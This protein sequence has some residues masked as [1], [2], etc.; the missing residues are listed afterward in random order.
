MSAV[1]HSSQ[2]SHAHRVLQST[3]HAPHHTAGCSLL[4]VTPSRARALRLACVRAARRAQEESGADAKRRRTK[5]QARAAPH[6]NSQLDAPTTTPRR[7]CSPRRSVPEG[8]LGALPRCRPGGS[9]IEEG[10]RRPPQGARRS[11]AHKKY[12]VKLLS[13]SAVVLTRTTRPTAVQHRLER[14][15]RLHRSPRAHRAR[16][17]RREGR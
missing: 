8:F 16:V 9:P 4:T 2:R 7:P 10:Q 5:K 6:R 15:H 3:P 13:A 1:F 12:I 17:D 14:H 11:R